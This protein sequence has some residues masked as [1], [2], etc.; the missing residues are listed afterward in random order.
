MM[1]RTAGDC[2]AGMG[3]ATMATALLVLVLACLA[4]GW[5]VPLVIGIARLRRKSAGGGGLA[6][7]IVGG[8]WGAAAVVLGGCGGLMA[9]VLAVGGGWVAA[10]P[11]DPSQYDGPMG[12]IAVPYEGAAA[13]EVWS[14]PSG[15]RLGLS[16]TD[17]RFQVPVGEYTPYSFTA[18]RTDA[19]GMP[20]SAHTFLT[21]ARPTP[22]RPTPGRPAQVSVQADR[23][24]PLEL[25][26]PLTASIVVRRQRANR[27][28]LD[29]KIV[30]SQGRRYTITRAGRQHMPPGFE[31]LSPSG[32]VVWQGC[33]EYG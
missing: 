6:L 17:G 30:D 9:F 12:S 27:V 7:T 22:G 32:E 26:P 1:R 4:L 20:W 10:E 18:K 8:V 11:F 31:V 19:D 28:N 13:L 25:G 15:K 33:F 23:A 2:S 5:L 14:S 16:T 21:T 3:S 29:L 24:V